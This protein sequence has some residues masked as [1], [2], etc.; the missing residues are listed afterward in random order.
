MPNLLTSVS[1]EKVSVRLKGIH[2]TSGSWKRLIPWKGGP[3]MGTKE[4]NPKA[5]YAATEKRELRPT[6]EGYARDATRS[7][8]GTPTVSKV[9]MDTKK[10][11]VPHAMGPKSEKL[12]RENLGLNRPATQAEQKEFWADQ[13]SQGDWLKSKIKSGGTPSQAATW[14]QELGEIYRQLNTLGSWRTPGTAKPIKHKTISP[15]GGN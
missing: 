12:V 2:G 15:P 6:I 7:R 4:V 13:V 3:R 11:W 8:S 9:I 1:F 14:R 10:G 5:V